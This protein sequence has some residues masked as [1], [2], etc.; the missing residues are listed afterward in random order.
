LYSELVVEELKSDYSEEKIKEVFS[1]F[2]ETLLKVEI[3]ENQ[4][5]EA[6][7]L[8]SSVRDSHLKDVLHTVLA[9]N[10]KAIMIT[11]DKHFNGLKFL[12]E[13]ARPEEIYF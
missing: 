13:V 4:I 1:S 3:S 5:S 6:H 9:K 10:N 2:K 8:L 11:R 7:K 12:G